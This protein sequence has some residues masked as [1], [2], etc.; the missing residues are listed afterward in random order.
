MIY[1]QSLAAVLAVMIVLWLISLVRRDV[2]IVDAFWGPGFLLAAG[3]AHLEGTGYAPRGWLLLALVAVWSLRLGI[4]LLWRNLD[5]GEEDYRYR[6][7]R[8]HWG[9]SFPLVSLG[10]IFLFQ[11]VL[12]WFISLTLQVAVLSDTP[13]RLTWLDALGVLLWLVGF[14]FESVGD[15]QLSR[16]K[17]DPSN[18]G[19]VLDSGLWRYTRH[20]NYFGDFM[21]WWGYF[22]IAL[23]TPQG[24]MTVL[25][26]LVMS[27]FL[28]KVS[29]VALLE[30]KLSKTRPKYRDYVERTNAFFPGPPKKSTA[31]SSPESPSD[32][33]A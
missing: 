18:Q 13:Q 30:K 1:L 28:L 20:P 33:A 22:C 25:S 7:M 21:V 17:A 27:I 15:W 10:T 6:K 8:D 12:L 4:Y 9:K 29:G 19:K 3:V 11:G 23:A 26:P 31:Q 14:V 24:W 5:H 32:D 2:S 16:F